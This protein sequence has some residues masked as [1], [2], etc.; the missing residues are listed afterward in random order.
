MM[1]YLTPFYQSGY[2]M[3]HK[4]RYHNSFRISACFYGENLSDPER[5]EAVRAV[6]CLADE[7]CAEPG[8]IT[9]VNDALAVGGLS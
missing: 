3:H 7:F 4:C 1:P 8:E 5:K 9:F 2:A 6:D